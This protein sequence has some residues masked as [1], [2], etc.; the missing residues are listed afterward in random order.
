MVTLMTLSTFSCLFGPPIKTPPVILDSPPFV[1]LLEITPN[2]D[3][4]VDVQRESGTQT[5]RASGIRDTAGDD[6]LRFLLEILLPSGKLEVGAGKMTPLPPEDGSKESNIV[7]YDEIFYSLDV[8]ATEIYQRDSLTVRLRII[9]NIP[10]LQQPLIGLEQYLLDISW[11][12][13]VDG[14]CPIET[15]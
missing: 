12:L 2:N 3:E 4:L 15:P 7:E 14:L 1:D 13:E 9:D 6:P 10:E 11:E 8:C 5:F